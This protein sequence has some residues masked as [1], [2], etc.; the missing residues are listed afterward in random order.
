MDRKTIITCALTGGTPVPNHPDYPITPKQIAD[1]GLAAADAG[2]AILHIHVRDPATGVTSNEI[3]LYREVIDRI[4]QKNT[5]VL[6]NL[7]TGYGAIFFPDPSDPSR[8]AAG[9]YVQR[10]EERVAHILELKPE[11][12]TLDLNTMNLPNLIVMN[13]EKIVTEMALAIRSAG[14]VPEIEIFDTGDLVMA[15]HLIETGVLDGP[16]LWSLVLG[17]RYSLPATT[18]AMVYGKNNLPAGANWTGFGISR[19]QFPM[20]AQSFLLGGHARVGMEDNVYLAQ[21]VFTPDNATLVRRAR[22]ILENL[23]A[24]IASPAEA[25]RMIGIA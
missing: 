19:H 9:S 1:Q 6:L 4:R 18:D 17:L 14:V 13:S 15:R 21:G 12:C 22:T 10:A 2:A 3:A 7:S 5:E 23:G 8:A 25:R 16:G 24:S 11:I 20:V